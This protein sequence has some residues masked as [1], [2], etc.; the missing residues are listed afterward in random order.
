MKRIHYSWVVCGACTLVMICNMG[1]CSNI[2]SVYLPFIEASGIN[3]SEGSAMLSVRCAFSLISMFFVSSYYRRLSLRAG[4]G[5]ATALAALASAIFALSGSALAYDVGASLAGIAYGLGSSIPTSLLVSRWF[6]R[7]QGLALGICASGSGIATV[8]FPGVIT[9]LVDRWDLRAAFFW[10]GGFIIFS[11]I[12]AC[13]L[14]RNRP[15]D[16]GLT[17]YGC[18]EA[19]EEKKAVPTGGPL[20]AAGWMA[21]APALLLLGGVGQS[22]SGHMS[23]LATSSGYSNETAALCVSLFGLILTGGK[24]LYGAAADCIGVKRTTELFFS[25]LTA[26][27]LLPLWM[28]GTALWPCFLLSVLLGLGYPPCTVGVPL[29]AADFSTEATYE[30]TLKWLQILYAAGGILLSMLPGWLSDRFGNYQSSYGIFAV[31]TALSILL[32][33]IAYHARQDAGS[34]E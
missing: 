33:K 24:F 12:I 18:G 17:A 8:C 3:G 11:G 16:M 32:L 20:P 34:P 29:W 22:G 30:R 14:I 9:W 2:L 13:M 23:I 25:L 6:S 4:I 10:Q 5:I 27:L 19:R 26:G 1:L 31:S 15:E 21:L 28:D 7:R